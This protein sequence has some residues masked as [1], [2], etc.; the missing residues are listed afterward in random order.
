[1]ALRKRNPEKMRLAKIEHEYNMERFWKKLV[2]EGDYW[3]YG[4]K[5]TDVFMWYSFNPVKK[6]LVK[7]RAA[8][9]KL[10]VDKNYP[11]MEPNKLRI[12]TV[13]EEPDNVNPKYLRYYKES[14][15]E[16]LL[17][18][19]E[20]QDDGCWRFTGTIGHDGYGRLTYH[21][22]LQVAHRV[23][24]RLFT[25]TN[26]KG[27]LLHR[28]GNHTCV[29]PEHLYVG[30]AWDNYMDAVRH[31]AVPQPTFTEDEVR[32]M[33]TM[34]NAGMKKSN[35]YKTYFH[36]RSWKAFERAWDGE[37]FKHIQI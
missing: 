27:A 28:C 1:M 12:T 7:V 14:G 13:A 30:T 15:L 29:N 26:P 34:K 36:D 20:K 4:N 21:G 33:R 10:F 3:R 11:I 31:G 37:S 32:R 18:R 5:G 2:R 6:R 23:S 8:A 24:Y 25:G 9:Y 19:I 35:C 22:K 16:R 17:Q